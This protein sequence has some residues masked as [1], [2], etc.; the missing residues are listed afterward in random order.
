MRQWDIAGQ[1]DQAGARALGGTRSFNGFRETRRIFFNEVGVSKGSRK[2]LEGTWVVK[3]VEN[4]L[5]ERQVG[6]G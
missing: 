3:D 6:P 2:H 1:E 4:W 5:C